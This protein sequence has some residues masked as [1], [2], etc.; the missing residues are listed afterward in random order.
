MHP[1]IS[2]QEGEPD[3]SLPEETLPEEKRVFDRETW[4]LV[5]E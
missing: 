3:V 5:I 4:G 1:G 2:E